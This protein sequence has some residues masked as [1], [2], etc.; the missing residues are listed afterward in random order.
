MSE[1]IARVN[2]TIPHKY[3]VLIQKMLMYEFK[4][5]IPINL[6][7]PAFLALKKA[8]PKDGEEARRI[9]EGVIS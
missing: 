3:I 2:P 8:N 9:I 4:D 1:L 7:R 6:V 5:R